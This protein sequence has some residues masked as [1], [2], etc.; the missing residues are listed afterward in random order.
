MN[1]A[2]VAFTQPYQ[3]GHNT[4]TSDKFLKTTTN[5]CVPHDTAS[6][7]EYQSYRIWT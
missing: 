6:W 4:P 3:H 7:L 1:C 2:Y 5:M